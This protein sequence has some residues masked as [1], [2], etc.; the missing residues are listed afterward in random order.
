MDR[1][2]YDDSSLLFAYGDR[3][4]LMRLSLL[5]AVTLLAACGTAGSVCGCDDSCDATLTCTST[6]TTTTS[7]PTCA[8]DPADGDVA[9]DCG[10][11]VSA[12]LGDD[13]NPGTQDAPVKT[14]QRGVDL[15][16]SGGRV[17]ACAETYF[18]GVEIPA[19]VSL[20]GGWLCQNGWEVATKKQRAT[21]APVHDVIPVVLT[22]GDGTSILSD[23][24]V[25]AADAQ[26]AGG[27]S[28]ALWA[29]DDSAA[30]IRRSLLEAGAG[31]RGDDGKIGGSDPAANGVPGLPGAGAC[32]AAIGAGGLAPVT[33]CDGLDAS[34]GG[35]GGDGSDAFANSGGT[36][37]PN[38]GGGIGGKGEQAA[39]QCTDGTNGAHGPDGEDGIGA[40][41]GGTLTMSAFV[42]ADGVEGKP[43]AHAQGGGGGGASYGGIGC[44]PFPKGGAG[45]GSGGSGGCGGRAGRGGGGGGASIALASRSSGVSLVSVQLVAK[46]GGVGGNGGSGQTGGNGGLP[47]KGGEGYASQ[48]PINHGCNGG[49]GGNGGRGGNGGGGAGGPSIGIAHVVGAAPAQ[50]DVTIE[51][52]QGGEGGL[53]GVPDPALVGESGKAAQVL[54]LGSGG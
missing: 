43:G 35:I 8:A 38:L 36:G 10:I 27:S 11:W 40:A 45:G 49:F 2:D 41:A 53:G 46:K 4:I 50:K 25:R 1:F 29:G 14:L 7:A 42:G 12:T 21:I 30:E 48:Q 15:A 16:G 26:T 22:A 17:Y 54:E 23:L 39:P 37:T 33:T 9:P 32:T 44:G 20:N 18:D 47:G 19:G 6:T 51:V 34:G 13:A 3:V 5:A 24:V 28:I 52:G 31:A